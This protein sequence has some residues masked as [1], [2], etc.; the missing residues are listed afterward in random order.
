MSEGGDGLHLDDV[1]ILD[2][3]IQNTRGIDD[4]PSKVLVIGVSNVQS[5]GR[6]RVRRRLDISPGNLVHERTLADV[7]ESTDDQG[8]GVGIDSGQTVQMLSNLLQEFQRILLTLQDGRHS[9]ERGTLELLGS[10]QTV[11]E[12]EQ[13]EVILG[14][15]VDEMSSLVELT[16]GDL[17]VLLVVENVEEM[18]QEWMQVFEDGEFGEDFTDSLVDGVGAELDL[19]EE[20]VSE[21]SRGTLEQT[22]LSHVKVSN[23]RDLEV[24]VDNRGQLFEFED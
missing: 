24:L 1:H 10:V 8:S 21:G 9:T 7:G 6:E 18:H 16:E 2:I 23:T 12:L 4:L 20:R 22:Y 15:L 13:S 11:G 14:N 17:P 3:V 5:L 19:N